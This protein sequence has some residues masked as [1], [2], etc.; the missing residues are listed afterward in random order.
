MRHNI[1]LNRVFF[2]KDETLIRG[3]NLKYALDV[4][5]T[6]QALTKENISEE[7]AREINSNYIRF[8]EERNI[9]KEK[10]WRA[11]GANRVPIKEAVKKGIF[12]LF[13]ETVDVLQKMS[14]DKNYQIAVISQ[15]HHGDTIET[16]V[17]MGL[18]PYINSIFGKIDHITGQENKFPQ[19]LEAYASLY[20]QDPNPFTKLWIVGDAKND[21]NTA[22]IALREMKKPVQGILVD[23]INATKAAYGIQEPQFSPHCIVPNLTVA[24]EHINSFKK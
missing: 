12:K 18:A 7:R 2:D 23:R 16:M 24:K 11:Y 4:Q 22:D 6:V 10:Y 20:A 5:R 14:E 3:A 1:T 13:P 19:F 17:R 21:M 9:S 15:T 8:I